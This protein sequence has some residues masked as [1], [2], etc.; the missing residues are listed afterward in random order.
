MRK[1]FN[2]PE[3]RKRLAGTNGQKYWRSLEEIA[4]TDEFKD[5]LHHEFPQGADQ[6]LSPIGRR[7]FLKLMGASLALGGLAACNPQQAEK[8]V[9]YVKAPEAIIPGQPMY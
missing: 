7:N 5:F 1:N 2:L 4:E 3:I 9:P 6:W 8:I